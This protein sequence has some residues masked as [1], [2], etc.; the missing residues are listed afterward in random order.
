MVLRLQKRRLRQIL[1]S[2]IL[3]FGVIALI[4][5]GKGMVVNIVV[6]VVAMALLGW[7]YHQ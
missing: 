2:I 7:A 3:V 4:S 5:L 6:E 1:W